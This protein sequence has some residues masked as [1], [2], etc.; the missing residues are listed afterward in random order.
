VPRRAVP[1]V[2][3]LSLAQH[4]GT[5]TLT[6]VFP[7]APR[8]SR[9]ELLGAR[10]E[11]VAR[12]ADTMGLPLHESPEAAWEPLNDQGL[13]AAAEADT[14]HFRFSVDDPTPPSWFPYL[15]RAVA[16][17]THDLVNGWLPGRSPQSNLVKAERLPAALPEMSGLAGEETA[18]QTVR[19]SFRSDAL[20][21]A[22]PHGSF[23][24]E[25]F[26]WDY[27]EKKFAGT[28]AL[29]TWLPAATLH[30]GGALSKGQ[31]YYSAPDADSKRLFEALLE[32]SGAAFLFRVRL[33]DPLNRT[34]ERMVSGKVQ[35]NLAPH[36]D[37]LGVRRQGRDLFLSFESTTRVTQPPEGEYRLDILYTRFPGR[38]VT[39]L[40]R[41][42]HQ[43]GVGDLE[44]LGSSPLTTILR[45][46][47]TSP[48]APHQY[49][50]VIKKFHSPGSFPAPL[51]GRLQIRLTAP[52]GTT[53]RLVTAI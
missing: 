30:P 37:K 36:L 45:S 44:M 14:S 28:P 52:D 11:F 21:E 17:G 10:R 47:R 12:E 33:T 49:G 50:A 24:L 20:V 18:T 3:Q 27:D 5:A 26:A 38:T 13:P 25:V 15:Y 40:T 41:A 19:L 23:R 16:V 8:P 7:K 22:T 53:A 1:A 31:L 9:V 4:N 51:R 43:I 32:V 48:G 34:T 35:Q 6:C 46:D 39:L 29:S 42:L 2:P